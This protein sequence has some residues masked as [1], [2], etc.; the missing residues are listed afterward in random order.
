MKLKEL[1]RPAVQVWSPA[2]Q[3]P[4]YLA[5][6]TSAQQLDASFSTNA[7]LEIFEVDFRDPSVDLQRRGVLTASSRFHKLI[8]GNGGSGPPENSG[9]IVGGGDNG[10]I[11]LFSAAQILASGK[12]PVIGQR[13]K[14]TGPVRALDFNPFQGN[15]LASGANDSEI[16]IWDLNNFSVP[17]TPGSKSQYREP[18]EDVSALCWNRQVQHILS[19]AHP[20]GKA[21]VWDLRK[22][23]P[24]IKVSDHSNRM[25]CS[26]MAWHPEVAT[27]LVLSSEDDRLPA[28]QVWD[29]RF[30]TS[31]LKVL[32]NHTRGVLS[33][34]W[35]Q[36]DPELLLSSAKDNRIL[37]WNPG[38]G[39]VVYELPTR[40]RWCFDVQ[41][42]PRNPSVFAAAS[43]DGWINL[44]SVMG[45]SLEAQRRTQADKISSSF[46]S[47][48]PFGTGQ[49]L[50]PLQVPEQ[51]VQTTLVPPLKKP[52][53]W[54]RRPVGGS[55]AFGGK[56][57]TSFPAQ[58]TPQPCPHVVFIS[59]VT[60]EPE[61]LARSAELQEALGSGNL[62][63]Y[64]QDKIQRAKL[65]FEKSVWQF[66]KVNLEQESRPK[67]LK[68]LG[69]S[70]EELRAKIAASGLGSSLGSGESRHPEGADV[71]W[72]KQPFSG[73][74][75]R[76]SGEPAT[77]S[78][79]SAFFDELMPQHLTSLEIPVT[80]DTDGL[81]SQ[82]LLLGNL[83]GAVDLCVREE[84][85]A[86]AIILAVAGG[87][88]LLRRTQ[89]R[90]FAKKKT[91]LSSLLSSIV[92]HRW[93]DVVCTCSLQN[94]REA[95]AILLTYSSQEEYAGLCDTLG[96]RLESEGDGTLSPEACLC[97]I[98]SGNVERLVE[99]WGKIHK[100]SS[101]VALQDLVEKVMV[102]SRS[103]ELLRGPAGASPGPA[104]V[105][106]VTDYASLLASQG[107]LAAAVSY[108]PRDSTQQSIQ[109][110]RERLFHAQGASVVGQQPP[111]FPFPRVHV[112]APPSQTKS[113]VAAGGSQPQRPGVRPPGQVSA[114]S[115][116]SS[117]FT[118]QPIPAP[119]HAGPAQGPIRAPTA[120]YPRPSV[121]WPTYP[122]YAVPGSTL[123]PAV[124]QPFNPRG[125]PAP[126]PVGF[127]V[128]P[129][130]PGQ[131]AHMA[132]P[133]ALPPGSTFLPP[134]PA[135]A[136]Q[137]SAPLTC[138][139]SVASQ[140]P[141]PFSFPTAYPQGG[142][143]A[144]SSGPPPAAGIPPPPSGPQESWS[145][146]S[147]RGGLQKKKL[148]PPAPI[149]APVMSLPP[150]GVLLRGGPLGHEAGQA[151]PGAPQELSLQFHQLP[152]ER[153]ERKEL[154]PEHLPLKTTFEGLV[155]RCSLVAADPTK[156]KLEEA[157]QRL[158]CLYEKLRE[159]ALSPHILAGLHEIARCMDAQNYQQ[160]LLVHTQVVGSSSFSEVSG[161]MPVLK[162]VLTIAHKLN[163]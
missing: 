77:S 6:G 109:Q 69:Y 43:F 112:G 8:W 124:P 128:G 2:S 137:L 121:P 80:S 140:P 143:G 133:G 26:A 159:Q 139:V 70:E 66:L 63:E 7:A 14:H 135:P 42:C 150:G 17:M 155:Q 29:L 78:S 108:L 30:A 111:P 127:P 122:T 58:Q 52:P 50:P 110:L 67:L 55:F 107:R 36:A 115:P 101:P 46:S 68:L 79:S 12:E 119:S 47:L 53:K 74:G 85:F 31:P 98:C 131:P 88:K 34:S 94:W 32:E 73:Q 154:P 28:I 118:P 20:S 41:W 99:C 158:E 163:V 123:G 96:A 44:Y 49:P 23:E 103:L 37:C 125:G 59:Q 104:T 62:L 114:P 86:D 105:G 71:D 15:L 138:P 82:A 145:D 13:E 106:R 25:H 146:P 19:S 144:P 38:S 87:E 160:G 3:H 156:R 11:T 9:V 162:A 54:I 132:P 113:S 76:E 40:S 91:R 24:I 84:R 83:D 90:Y 39:E 89:Q 51:V 148:A 45:G 149:T 153:V 136:P 64:C 117:V 56:L 61:F 22:N 5:T 10:V 151:P 81:I 33:V 116:M 65:Q 152:P 18:P 142:P 130:V 120:S 95:M 147:R 100:A 16:F 60:T 4:I 102:L 141:G 75:S 157:S 21:V 1:E 57:V 129:P 92:Q 134:G 161:F 35:C 72:N 97:Y 48:D 126:G 93:R 27:Q